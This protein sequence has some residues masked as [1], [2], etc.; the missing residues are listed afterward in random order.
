MQIFFTSV[1]ASA[2]GNLAISSPAE[3]ER[4]M[5]YLTVTA[6]VLGG[7]GRE[8]PS[9]LILPLF[10]EHRIQFLEDVLVVIIYIEVGLH[11]GPGETCIERTTS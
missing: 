8:G 6:L 9:L 3:R 1:L 5:P 4:G 2:S 11:S 7:W 10:Q